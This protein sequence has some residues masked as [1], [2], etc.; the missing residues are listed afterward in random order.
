MDAKPD[1]TDHKPD[2]K[3]D[4]APPAIIPWSDTETV[5]LE[6]GTTHDVDDTRIFNVVSKTHRY[7]LLCDITQRSCILPKDNEAYRLIDKGEKLATLKDF[8]GEY[9]K[10]QTVFLMPTNGKDVGCYRLTE[11]QAL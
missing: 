6:S 10:G 4:A 3:A 11:A 7:A 2:V 9:H 5:Y 8:I 1:V